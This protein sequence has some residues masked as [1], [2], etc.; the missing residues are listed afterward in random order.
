MMTEQNIKDLAESRR[1]AR[2]LKKRAL[3]IIATH[4]DDQVLLD[5]AL[6]SLERAENLAAYVDKVEEALS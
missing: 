6:M 4:P 5:C 2:R 1:A 3:Q